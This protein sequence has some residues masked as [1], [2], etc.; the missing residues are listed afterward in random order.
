M[1]RY[2][3]ADKL[4]NRIKA[5]CV[6]PNI[7]QDGYFLQNCTI[8]LIDKQPT[9]DVV[10]VVRCKDCKQKGGFQACHGKTIYFCKLH[11]FCVGKNDFCSCG[12][13]KEK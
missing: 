9:A 3:D 4:K 1:A 8:D 5:S 10:E 12:E 6:F 13:R 7:G 2:I 11:K